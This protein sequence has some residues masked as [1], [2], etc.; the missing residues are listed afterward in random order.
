MS[1]TLE[2]EA[3]IIGSGFGGA[4]M[5][6]RLARQWPGRVLLLER[7]K[8]YPM[9]GFPRSPHDLADNV[10]CADGDV[11]FQGLAA[12]GEFFAGK[13]WDVYGPHLPSASNQPQRRYP[14]F[15]TEGVT[16]ADIGMHPFNTAD[17]LGLQL[18]RFAR[19]PSPAGPSASCW[20][21]RR[22]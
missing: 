20:R 10:W 19:V 12:F 22:T 21:W 7:G 17:G 16:G 6:A 4:V 18:T 13:L 14:K 5:C 8:A 9:G 11:S 2:H 15:T 3:V 1:T